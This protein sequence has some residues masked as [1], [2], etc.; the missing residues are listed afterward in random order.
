M[1]QQKIIYW[2]SAHNISAT[3]ADIQRQTTAGSQNFSDAQ[4]P[5]CYKPNQMRH[6]LMEGVYRCQQPR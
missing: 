2:E 3:R 5:S 1:A 4:S 6:L